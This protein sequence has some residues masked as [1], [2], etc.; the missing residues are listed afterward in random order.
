MQKVGDGT[1][2]AW[3]LKRLAANTSHGICQSCRW[4][5]HAQEIGQKNRALGLG[6]GRFLIHARVG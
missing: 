5:S 1:G 2:C 6:N 3:V 4:L